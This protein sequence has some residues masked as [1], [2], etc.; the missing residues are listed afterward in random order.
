MLHAVSSTVDEAAV[1][2]MA[3]RLRARLASGDDLLVALGTELDL[4]FGSESAVRSIPP[5]GAAAASRAGWFLSHS[6][7]FVL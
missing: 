3:D 5:P 6:F 7:C 2:A 4:L 1:P